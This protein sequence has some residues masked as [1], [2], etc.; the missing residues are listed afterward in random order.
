MEVHK[1]NCYYCKEDKSVSEAKAGTLRTLKK[2]GE[3]KGKCTPCHREYSRNYQF[4]MRSERSPHLFMDCDDCDKTFSVYET[5][6]AKNG[7][8]RLKRIECPYCGSEEII[9]HKE[10]A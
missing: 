10:R 6:S 7:A 2:N 8:Q 4:R 5:G 9:G 1:F 3:S